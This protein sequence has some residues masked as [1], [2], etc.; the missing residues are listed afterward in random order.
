MRSSTDGLAVTDGDGL[1]R[2]DAKAS[3]ATT[4]SFADEQEVGTTGLE[5]VKGLET[6]E[7]RGSLGERVEGK[8]VDRQL[9]LRVVRDELTS[10]DGI[11]TSHSP[12]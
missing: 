4:G 1:T 12:S 6:V 7:I 11:K 10:V 8:L 9:V 3:A 2:D 5:V